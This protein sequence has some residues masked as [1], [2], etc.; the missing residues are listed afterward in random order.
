MKRRNFLNAEQAAKKAAAD[1][2]CDIAG[3][4]PRLYEFIMDGVYDDGKPRETGTML[5]CF[6][7]GL[8]KAWLHDKDSAASCWVSGSTLQNVLDAAEAVFEEGCGEW[9]ATKPQK[10]R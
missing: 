4:Y 5:V 6:G 8:W 3:S 1:G 2:D 7:Q 10:G 9:R